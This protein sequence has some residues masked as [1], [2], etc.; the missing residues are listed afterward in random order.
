M[1]GLANVKKTIALKI[2][3]EITARIGKRILNPGEHLIETA[4]ADEFQTSRAPVREA[5]LMLERDRLVQRIPHHG[6]VVRRFTRNDIHELYDVIYRLEEISMEKAIAR[7][8][9]E[10]IK[11]LEEVVDKQIQ[12]VKDHNIEE[13][14]DLNE[15]FHNFIF[16]IA[17]NTVLSETY[18]SLR[19][20]AK[21]FRMLSMAQGSNLSSS[22]DEHKKQ[23]KA[24]AG[25]D[26][27]EGKLAIHEQEIRSLQSLDILFPE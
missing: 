4:I 14:Y 1:S 18:S 15:Q 3:E 17:G 11:N 19:R 24:L 23:V 13:Y 2:A 25:K 20:S 9:Q 5:L 12:A 27:S 7:V 8:S 10:D 21:P 22:L 16:S 26:V 6:V